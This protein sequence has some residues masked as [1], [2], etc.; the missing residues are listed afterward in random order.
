MEPCKVRQTS[1]RL[2]QQGQRQQ[3][4][5]RGQ[6]REVQRRHPGEGHATGRRAEPRSAELGI[7]WIDSIT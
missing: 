5:Q 6:S 1:G 2:Q 4:R 3:Q 7:L